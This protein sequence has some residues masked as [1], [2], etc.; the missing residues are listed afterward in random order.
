MYSTFTH[1]LVSSLKSLYVLYIQTNKVGRIRW[2][3]LAFAAGLLFLDHSLVSYIYTKH[4]NYTLVLYI[5][6]WE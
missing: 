1:F 3:F 4:M 5:S 2:K 6:F